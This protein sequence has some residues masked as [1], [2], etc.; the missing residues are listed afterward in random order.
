MWVITFY[1]CCGGQAG[2]AVSP[3]PIPGVG[4]HLQPREGGNGSRGAVGAA[5]RR[6]GTTMLP[7]E[8]HGADSGGQLAR[9]GGKVF[10]WCLI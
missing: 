3:K 10:S 2:P 9:A 1:R 8:G 6:G 5:L 4:V 7:R